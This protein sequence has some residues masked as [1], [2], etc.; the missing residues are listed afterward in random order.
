MGFGV[1]DSSLSALFDSAINSL[2][3]FSDLR[4]GMSCMVI[5]SHL[6]ADERLDYLMLLVR[7]K[8][9]TDNIELSAIVLPGG[10]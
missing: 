1:L 2:F 3:N 10:I 5:L 7:E 6:M 4:R 8:D 9:L